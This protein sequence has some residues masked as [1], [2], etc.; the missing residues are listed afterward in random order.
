M[1][2]RTAPLDEDLGWMLGVVLRAY[3]KASEHALADLP[4]GPRGYQ[5]LT[6][7]CA[8]V[9]RNQGTI[10]ED[11]GMDRT[12]MTYLI[13]D[14]ERRNLVVRRPDPADRRSRLITATAAGRVA[15]ESRRT[16]LRAV[17]AQVL[18]PLDAA[19]GTAFRGLL[20]SVACGAQQLDPLTD[21][22]TAVEQAR[23]PR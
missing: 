12:V 1:T 11:L 17:E 6:A 3:A 2:D 15:W 9:P 7:A 20:R 14:L 19:A 22:C 16:A 23:V 13:D 4:G 5:V 8:D 18:A 10:A 21:L